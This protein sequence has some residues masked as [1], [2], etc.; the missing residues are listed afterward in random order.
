[1][2]D[3]TRE[4]L[5]M[6]YV[7]AKSGCEVVTGLLPKISDERLRMETTKQLE[8]YAGYAR[9]AETIME[10]KNITGITFPLM[11]KLSVRGGVMMETAGSPTQQE[12]ARLLHVS[13]QDSAKRIR[14]AVTD[15][16]N[17][18]CDGDVLALGRNMAGFEAEEANSLGAFL[19]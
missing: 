18:G 13:S 8:A 4:L 9:R 11:S 12:L 10:A 1:M 15:L 17:S 14:Q 6:I 7:D 5:R 19:T 3:P 16:G 2:N